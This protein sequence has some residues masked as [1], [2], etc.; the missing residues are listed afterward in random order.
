MHGYAEHD[1][2]SSAGLV[3]DSILRSHGTFLPQGVASRASFAPFLSAFP[4]H[5]RGVTAAF[6]L[7]LP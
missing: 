3:A 1:E 2:A 5:A 4:F 7:T 6:F